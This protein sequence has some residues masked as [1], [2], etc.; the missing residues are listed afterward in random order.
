MAMPMFPA[1]LML[2]GS[3]ALP[4]SPR[5]L[6]IRGRLRDALDVIH[7]ARG[8]RGGQGRG[9]VSTAAVEAELME[10]VGGGEGTR[11]SRR[12]RRRARRERRR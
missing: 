3:A 1:V 7:P 4:E 6:V 11:P 2:A 9:D 8:F 5:W 12:A 10:V